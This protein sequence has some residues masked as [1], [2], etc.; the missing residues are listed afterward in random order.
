MQNLSADTGTNS[1]TVIPPPKRILIIEDNPVHQRLM[2]NVLR[3]DYELAFAAD[4]QAAKVHLDGGRLLKFDLLILD[5]LIP[6]RPGEQPSSQEAIRILS[7]AGGG[8]AIVVVSGSPT[9]ELKSQFN[10][11]KVRRIFEKPFSL[12]EFRDY[13]DSLLG[14]TEAGPRSGQ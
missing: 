3:A 7:N 10:Q 9:N 5:S 12:A 11:F 14:D 6:P 4:A 8:P 2:A 13:V 1:P